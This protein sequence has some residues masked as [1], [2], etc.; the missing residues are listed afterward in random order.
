MPKKVYNQVVDHRLY[1]NEM[2][3]EDVTSVGLPTIEHPTTNISVAGMAMDIDVPNMSHVNAMELT[4]NHNNGLNCQHLADPGQH[5]ISFRTARQVYNTATGQ[6]G[7]ESVKFTITC[8]H[9]S[10]EEGTIERGNPYGSTEKYSIQRYLK[11]I[12]GDTVTLI[13][14]AA[15]I[16][17]INGKDYTSPVEKLLS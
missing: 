14:S 15:S 17:T 16:I 11:E 12:D 9:K 1:N 4:I 2:L 3:T 5:I 7:Y 10:T 8:L 6:M 13:D